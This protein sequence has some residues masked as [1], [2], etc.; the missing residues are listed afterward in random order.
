MAKLVFGQ[1]II[2]V[3]QISQSLAKADT[4]VIIFVSF[5]HHSNLSEQEEERNIKSQP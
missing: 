3:L 4:L 1:I 2:E 5:S